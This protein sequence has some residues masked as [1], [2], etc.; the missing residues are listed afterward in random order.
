MQLLDRAKALP[1][2]ERVHDILGRHMLTDGYPIVLDLEA[3]QGFRLRDARTGREYLDLFTFYASNPLGVNHP[4]LV[5]NDEFRG[6][7]MDAA[8]NKVANS[9]IYTAHMARFV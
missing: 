4:K 9:D 5:G 7:L 3:S 1:D 6:R 2:A 8:L